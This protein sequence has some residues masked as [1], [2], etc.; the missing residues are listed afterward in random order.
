M[1]FLQNPDLNA[2][3]ARVQIFAGVQIFEQAHACM[4]VTFRN[5]ADLLFLYPEEY[6]V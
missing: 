4:L 6:M 5:C 3:F 2:N 1:K